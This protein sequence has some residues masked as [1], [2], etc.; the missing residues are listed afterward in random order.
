MVAF[1]VG[2]FLNEGT[3]YA[4]GLNMCKN[5]AYDVFES[6]LVKIDINETEFSALVDFMQ[7][8]IEQ[9]GSQSA[10]LQQVYGWIDASSPECVEHP[11]CEE[12]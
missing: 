7:M 4:K 2:Y 1:S 3:G 10:Q 11:S 9:G 6:D 12:R 5:I 8:R